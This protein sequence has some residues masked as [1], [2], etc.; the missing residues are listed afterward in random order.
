MCIA[1]VV[2]PGTRAGWL[3]YL[4]LRE[5]DAVNDDDES[6]CCLCCL[7]D[8]EASSFAKRKRSRSART[9][10]ARSRA[11]TAASSS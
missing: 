11:A 1:R 7:S 2:R 6:G 8:C 4:W 3:S 10:G 5:G 9:A